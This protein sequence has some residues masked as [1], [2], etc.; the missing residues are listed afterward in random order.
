MECPKCGADNPEGA[1]YCSLCLDKL[2]VRRP[3]HDQTGTPAAGTPVRTDSYVAPGEWRG[4]AE[5]LRP[6]AS[7]VVESKM[8]RLYIRLGIYGFMALGAIVWLVLSLTVWGNP[9]PEKQAARLLEAVNA[10]NKAAFDELILPENQP[11]GEVLYKEVILVLG[12]DGRF[13]DV[14]FDVVQDDNY[15]ARASIIGGVITSSIYG[16]IDLGETKKLVLVM[17][18]HKG[19]W[20]FNPRD[21]ILS[22]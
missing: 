12:N 13:E 4:D 8:R 10:R 20:Y 6:A 11:A 9:S 5:L 16:R 7:K 18:N 14:T 19:K 22:P 15:T 3:S 21:S 2:P 1:E 17:E